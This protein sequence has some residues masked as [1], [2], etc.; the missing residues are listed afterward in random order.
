MITTR[1]HIL[2]VDDNPANRELLE[3][4]LQP[5]G[6]DVTL[7][8]SG[9]EC[10]DHVASHHVD[11]VMLDV[12]MPGMDGFEVAVA[13]RANPETQTIPILMIT[14][15]SDT[16]DR[17][18]GIECGC[19]DF[20]SKPFDRDEVLARTRSMI[21]MTGVRDEQINET[22]AEIAAM[23][24]QLEAARRVQEALYPDAVPAIDGF[25]IWGHNLSSL[26]VSGDYYDIIAGDEANGRAIFAIADVSGKGAPAALL[27]S[28]LHA[29]LHSQAL[30]PD[31]DVVTATETL[32]R[33]VALHSPGAIFATMLIGELVPLEGAVRYVR[34]GHELPC[35]VD[36]HGNVSR[37]VHGGGVLGIDPNMRYPAAEITME[38]GELL[39]L[40][41]D[42]V[43][44]AEDERGRPFGVERL[45]GVLASLRD[46]TAEEAGNA[47]VRAVESFSA[48]RVDDMTF[49]VIRRTGR[50]R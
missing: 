10:L 2:V 1:K 4:V 11:V 41:T 50:E 33:L 37:P 7:V 24:R 20:I 12:M 35:L 8:A 22:S 46:R 23:R 15:L 14:A 17:I 30:D 28:S 43:T 34:A 18:T 29:A 21:R 3:E 36:R 13:L 31:F 49:I 9:A 44:D 47:I 45:E 40:Y 25:D 42:G 27:A 39:C 16:Q 6:Y 48:D 38:P 32:N 5:Q 19:D 26:E